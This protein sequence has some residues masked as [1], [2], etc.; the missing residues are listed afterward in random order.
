M[1]KKFPLQ[2]LSFRLIL[3][4]TAAIITTALA[5]GIPAYSIIRSELVDQTWAQVRDGGQRAVKFLDDEKDRLIKLTT[6]AAQR[7]RSS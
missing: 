2:T 4:S 5:A 6:L 1:I 3:A 7:P